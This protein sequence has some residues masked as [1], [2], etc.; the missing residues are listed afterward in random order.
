[1]ATG[2]ANA[3]GTA[4]TAARSDHVHQQGVFSWGFQVDTLI[5]PELNQDAITDARIVL[6]DSGLTHYLTFLDWAAADLNSISHLPVGAHIGLRQ[7]T[8]TRLLQVEA[9]WDAT[10]DRYQ[11]INVNTGILTEGASGTATELLLTAGAGGGTTVEANPAGTD[12]DDL[13]RLAVDG[14]NYNVPSGG[15]ATGFTE[16]RAPATLS[17]ADTW[18]ATGAIIPAADGDEWVRMNGNFDG[19]VPENFEFLSSRLRVLAEHTVGG[20]TSTGDVERLQFH[21]GSVFQRILMARTSANEII[22]RHE[23]AAQSLGNLSVY[24]YSAIAGEGDL[25]GQRVASIT[26]GAVPTSGS[27][28]E[29][30]ASGSGTRLD[31]GDIGG[32]GSDVGWVRDTDAPTAFTVE[33][34]GAS[35]DEPVI[36]VPQTRATADM[37]GYL[38]ELEILP[39]LGTLSNAISAVATSIIFTAESTETIAIGDELRIESEVVTVDAVPADGAT[40]EAARTYGIVRGSNAATHT[41]TRAVQRNEYEL[42]SDGII[43]Q[44]GPS[45][46]QGGS[47]SRSTVSL[48]T[49]GLVDATGIRELGVRLASDRS[50]V[51]LSGFEQAR[52]IDLISQGDNAVLLP[53]TRITVYLAVIAGAAAA[54]ESGQESPGTEGVAE[55]T[56]NLVTVTFWK[57]VE[58]SDGK[59]ADPGAH[60][61]FDDEWDGTT[62]ESADGGGWYTSRATALDEADNNPDF[63]EDTFTLWIATE[64]VRRRVVNDAYSY[65]DGGYTVTAAWD[66]QYSTDGTTWVSTEPDLNAYVRYRDQETGEFGPTI[67]V[68]TNVGSNDWQPIRTNDLVYPGGANQDELDAVYD[69]GNFSELLFFVASYREV[70]VPDDMGGTMV[71]GVNGPWH[72]YI[73]SRGGGW[74]VADAAEGED[75]NDADDGSCFQFTY[76]ATN[77]GVGLQ[78]WERGDDYVDPGNPPFLQENAEPPTQLGGHFKIVSTDGDEAH[79]T[80]FRFFAFSHAFARTTMSIFAR[81]RNGRP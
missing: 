37:F 68:G 47:S 3:E 11:V 8:T 41:N 79:V 13:T 9:V 28:L 30:T 57:W 52:R 31:S 64:Q 27:S 71:I 55:L 18:T 20:T 72:Q 44:G 38:V 53:S 48:G 73:V 51:G 62:P 5:V 54:A 1:M 23:S 33:R 74:P 32:T 50:T 58:T 77:T 10:N 4:T 36:N 61:R 70:T 2:T 15:V 49:G 56:P 29:T 59:P 76:F 75:N 16:L 65:T 78:I 67:P 6:E 7:G 60:W 17:V 80:K 14:T 39:F 43:L 12:G 22:L 26:F 19:E 24:S 21:D 40:G 66:I 35:S 34:I 69:F 45:P 63:S 81:Y 25:K 42:E 46:Q